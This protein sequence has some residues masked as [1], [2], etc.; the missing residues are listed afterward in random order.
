MGFKMA[1]L[2][3]LRTYQKII[4]LQWTIFL[5]LK[6][7]SHWAHCLQTSGTFVSDWWKCGNRL[8]VNQNFG[9]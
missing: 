9:R 1:P 3:T 4:F 8:I 6:I 7:F 5:P 2:L